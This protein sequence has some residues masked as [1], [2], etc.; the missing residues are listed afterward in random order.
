QFEA[1]HQAG[2][3][4]EI[5]QTRH[6][7]TELVDCFYRGSGE[8]AGAAKA[9][10]MQTLGDVSAGFGQAQGAQQAGSGDS[11]LQSLELRALQNGEEFRLA[12]QNDLQQLFVI[13][14]RV[15]EQAN[16]FQQLD[17]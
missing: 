5:D 15:A 9:S 3:G 1:S 17:G 12:A 10:G 6:A 7:I 14:I 8:R 13:G 2:I 16:F 4:Q 11:L